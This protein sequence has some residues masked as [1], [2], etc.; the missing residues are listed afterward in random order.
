MDRAPM[1]STW[2]RW[3]TP[4]PRRRFWSA[5]RVVVVRDAGRLAAADAARLVDVP[6]GPAGHRPHWCWWPAGGRVPQAL[7]KLATSVG[8]LVDTKVGIGRARSQWLADHL[9][10]RTGAAGRRRHRPALGDHLGEDMGRLEGLLDTLAAAYGPGATVQS[11]S[12]S[13]SW[14]TPVRLAPWDL[15][16]AID[17]GDIPRALDALR[18]LLGR[19]SHPLRV[20][21]VAPRPLPADAAARRRPA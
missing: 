11:T 10:R 2:A 8:G 1:P 4:A 19:D 21:A 12:S 9:Q 14:A 5:R 15:T 6:G 3:S 7:S 18:R 16:D 17:A 20:M 13:R